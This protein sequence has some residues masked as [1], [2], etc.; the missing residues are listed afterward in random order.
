MSPSRASAEHLQRPHVQ[1]AGSCQMGE[2]QR[3][4]GHTLPAVL[5]PRPGEHR[6]HQEPRRE[7]LEEEGAGGREP[8]QRGGDE[9]DSRPG[10]GR[11]QRGGDQVDLERREL[12]PPRAAVGQLRDTIVNALSF[13]WGASWI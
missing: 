1:T 6:G 11:G 9:R 13:L 10:R 4:E 5:Q 3:R 8:E 12:S 2:P 7:E